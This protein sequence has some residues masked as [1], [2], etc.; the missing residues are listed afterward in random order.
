MLEVENL[1][2]GCAIHLVATYQSARR[3]SLRLVNLVCLQRLIGLHR[4][5][6]LLLAKSMHISHNTE[7]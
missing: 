3:L 4:A 2:V 7:V 5:I 6:R 1:R